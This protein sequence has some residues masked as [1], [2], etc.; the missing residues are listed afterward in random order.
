MSRPRRRMRKPVSRLDRARLA[1]N[2]EL[3]A[4]IEERLARIRR[5]Q[6]T[7]AEADEAFAGPEPVEPAR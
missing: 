1:R 5:H 7:R 3:I 4:V 6:W 2:D